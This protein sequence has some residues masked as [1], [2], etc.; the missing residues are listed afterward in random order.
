MLNISVLFGKSA[1]SRQ[2]TTGPLFTATWLRVS[3]T[4]GCDSINVAGISRSNVTTSPANHWRWI[5]AY[6]S[7]LVGIAAGLPFIVMVAFLH[8]PGI[9]RYI[10][11]GLVEAFSI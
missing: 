9:R 1:L 5:T 7:G 6:C 4:I 3:S 11:N 10:E 2:Y 8:H